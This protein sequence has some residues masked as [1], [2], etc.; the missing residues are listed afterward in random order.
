MNEDQP[1]APTPCPERVEGMRSFSLKSAEAE[2]VVEK[3]RRPR[4][5]HLGDLGVNGRGIGFPPTLIGGEGERISKFAD[6]PERTR[7][8]KQGYLKY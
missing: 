8:R 4:E 7:T 6:L 5:L 2:A 1:S 3:D